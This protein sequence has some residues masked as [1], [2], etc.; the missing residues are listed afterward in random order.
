MQGRE[1]GVGLGSD[2]GEGL[3]WFADNLPIAL[4]AI[5][6]CKSDQS[7]PKAVIIFRGCLIAL[8][9]P[10]HA[11]HS[12]SPPLGRPELVTHM[13]HSLT[14]TGNRQTLGFR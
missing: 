13:D 10:C 11:D 5:L 7:Q 14:Q 6:L 4:A 3:E 8:C 12:A 2:D 9:G 1:L